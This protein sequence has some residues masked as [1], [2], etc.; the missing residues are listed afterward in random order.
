MN[1]SSFKNIQ[2]D[3][4][5]LNVLIAED[6]STNQLVLVEM[7]NILKC[8]TTIARDGTEVLQKVKTSDFDLIL[9]DCKMPVLDG[10]QT[11]KEIRKLESGKSRIPIVATT[12]SVMADDNRRIL[13]SGM[14]D[15][16]SKP[17]RLEDL[18]I[19]L[20]RWCTPRDRLEN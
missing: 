18:T 13:E 4:S 12:A 15:L 3:F 8:Q 5:H 2:A 10:Y 17:F 6:D 19:I 16:L 9:M 1:S 7:F 14:D 20:N 11:T